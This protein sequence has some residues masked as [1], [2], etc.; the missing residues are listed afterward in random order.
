ME[1]G[2]RLPVAGS[3]NGSGAGSMLGIGIDLE[4]RT[5]KSGDGAGGEWL[6]GAGVMGEKAG[7]RIFPGD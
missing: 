2:L 3:T 4:R 7:A 5:P 1:E 6:P